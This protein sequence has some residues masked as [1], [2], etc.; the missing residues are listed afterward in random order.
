MGRIG[1]VVTRTWQTAHKMKLQRG[2][3]D[4]DNIGGQ[5]DNARIKRY[6]AK[7]TINPARTHGISHLVGSVE[8]GKIADLV[9]WA[10][11]FFGVKPE[12]VL[13]SGSISW[14]QMGDPNAS[15]PTPQPSW[16]RPMFA[17]FG[18][19]KLSSNITFLP[20][21]AIND[22]LPAR[23]KLEKRIEAVRNCRS[24]AKRDMMHNDATPKIEVDAETYEVRADGEL[25]TSEPAK[26]L[27]MTQRYFLF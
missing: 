20:Q 11:A 5:N 3:L 19:S 6:I 9:I 1:E 21:A 26:E 15:I 12:A 24:I 25:L 18:R 16:G 27:P 22:G 2:P 13:K 14:S 23:L 8:A 7:Y 4:G 10:P 17:S